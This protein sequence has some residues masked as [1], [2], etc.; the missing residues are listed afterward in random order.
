MGRS[1][2]DRHSADLLSKKG[3][4]ARAAPPVADI[5][6]LVPRTDGTQGDLRSLQDL[7]E[8][9]SEHRAPPRE[10]WETSSEPYR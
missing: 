6:I 4:A 9:R 1:K 10:T 2:K 8:I 7:E 5:R 3:K